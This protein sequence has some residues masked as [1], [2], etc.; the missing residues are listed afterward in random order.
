MAKKLAE[1]LPDHSQFDFHVSPQLRARETMGYVLRSLGLPEDH[2]KHDKRLQELNFGIWEGKSWPELNAARIDPEAEPEAYH[3]WVPQDGE[4]YAE[5]SIRVRDWLDS[6]DRPVIT[7]AHGGISR[8]L[9]GIVL[10]LGKREIVQ[11]KVPQT[12]FYRL[13]DGG[14]DWFDASASDA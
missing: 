4:S 1:V 8:I 7:V 6:L 5:A 12:Q 3:D 13:A 10:N 14:I 2:P 11:L 9:R